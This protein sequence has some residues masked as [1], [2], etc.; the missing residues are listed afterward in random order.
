[1]GRYYDLAALQEPS[2]KT[3]VVFSYRAFTTD[4]ILGLYD[5]GMYKVLV[6]LD[7]DN[8]FSYWEAQYKEG[9]FI[10]RLFYRI[11]KSEAQKHFQ[12]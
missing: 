8:E 10:K 9:M 2:C 6:E 5:N 1:M 7:S 12:G 11:D 3:I 4:I